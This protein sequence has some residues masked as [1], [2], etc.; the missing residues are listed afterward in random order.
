METWQ[1]V[2]FAIV[3]F[4]HLTKTML[5]KQQK[6]GSYCIVHIKMLIA[7]LLQRTLVVFVVL[8]WLQFVEKKAKAWSG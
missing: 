5:M 3:F 1:C 2:G 6:W 7:R 4:F 8:V